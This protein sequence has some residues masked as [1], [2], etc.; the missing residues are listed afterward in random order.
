MKRTILP[1]TTGLARLTLGML[2]LLLA[3]PAFTQAVPGYCSAPNKINWPSANPVWSLCWINPE[4]S[5]GIDGSGLE[6]RHVFYKG[7]RVLWR[8]QMP[9]MNVLYDPGGCGGS[10]LSYR[11]WQNELVPFEANNVIAPGYAEPT[12]PVKTVCDHVGTDA[13]LFEGVAAEKLS[14][15]LILTTQMPAGWYRYIQKWTFYLDGRIDARL[16]FTV[17]NHPCAPK[18]HGHHAYWRFDFDIGGFANDRIRERKKFWFFKWWSTYSSEKK[19]RRSSSYLRK[20]RVQD[21]ISGLG[22]EVRPQSHDGATN[23]WADSDVWALRYHG[24]EIDDGGATGG[25]TGDAAHISDYLTGEGINGRDVVLWYRVGH[26]HEGIA[27]C[28]PL[29]GPTLVPLG[30]W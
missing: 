6:L 29:E 15:R 11:D 1:W 3:A 24:S 20:W 27:L 12:I 30:N 7:K 9:L 26:R 25:A 21:R 19:K 23:A 10:S 28:E 13:G 8:A 4:T 18:F 16:G 17:V 22:Y 2:V 14:D 5:S